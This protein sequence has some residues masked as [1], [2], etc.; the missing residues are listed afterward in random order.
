MR[1]QHIRFS[2]RLFIYSV[3]LFAWAVSACALHAGVVLGQVDTFESGSTLNW[4]N[5]HAPTITPFP[6]VA[7]GGPAGSADQ[8][9]KVSSD[10]SGSDGKLIAY[11]RSQW[12]GDYK[13]AGVTAIAMDLENLG[14]STLS[15]R[16]A[17]RDTTANGA[18]GYVSTVP[19]SLP[20]DSTWHHAV[21]SL[22]SSAMTPINSPPISFDTLM[23]GQELEMRILDS[24][25]PSLN[26]DIIVST[27]G[28]DNITAVPEPGAL[29][30]LF[31]A[32]G[33]GIAVY[34]SKKQ[35]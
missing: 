8:Y 2:A 5:G 22:A 26:G 6:V 13:T 31:F 11:N 15:M 30:L 24:A 19:F 35:N 16:I 34:A 4:T 21:F 23:A 18:P 29:T 33:A 12:L 3:A 9:L 28:I 14:A 20:A 1:F 25:S 10:G 7:L 17:F 32:A 27:V